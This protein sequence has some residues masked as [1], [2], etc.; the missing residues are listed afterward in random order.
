MTPVRVAVVGP[1]A[2]GKSAVA[3]AAARALGDVELIS[4]DSMQVY[5]GM[6][7]GTATP[8]P[9]E[10]AE[11][12]HHLLDLVDPSDEFTVAEFQRLYAEALADIAE[13]SRRAILVGG[14]GLYHRAVIDGLDLPGEWPDLRR[15]LECE[16]D[17]HGPEVLHARLAA[18]D[19]SAAARM[20][21]TN[22]RRIVR[23]LEVVEGSGRR[24]S[25]YG[26]GLDAYPPSPVTQIGVRWERAVLADRVERRVESMIAD[27][28]VDEVAAILAD[29]GLSRSA[30]QALGYKEIVSHLEGRIGL[31]EAVDRIIVRTRQFAV[32]QLR[33]FGRDPR[34]VWV[35]VVHDAVAE[36]TPAVLRAFAEA[37]E[38]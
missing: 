14:T 31:D 27:G 22:V 34:I 37:P 4:V 38:P 25:S 11:I 2:S 19:A 29:R 1:T 13:R 20:E 3:M 5:R 17:E 32:R 36:A 28:L 9:A 26:P 7:I 16:A 30:G 15:R 21:P 33:W 35:D 10:R 8:T 6:D 24:F 18:L 23:A 12:R